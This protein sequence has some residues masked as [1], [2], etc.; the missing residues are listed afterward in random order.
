MVAGD[1]Q[2]TAALAEVTERNVRAAVE[3]GNETRRLLREAEGKIVALDGL[4]R[5]QQETLDLLRSQLANIQAKL[6]KGP[7]NGN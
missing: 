4:V 1:R 3:H 7:T 5:Q 2:V 6:Y